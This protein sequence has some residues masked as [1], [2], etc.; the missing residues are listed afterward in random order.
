MEACNML[1]ISAA[2][3]QTCANMSGDNFYEFKLQNDKD[4]VCM[5][6]LPEAA[7]TG[8]VLPPPACLAEPKALFVLLRLLEGAGIVRLRMVGH[9]IKPQKEA[10]AAYD[11]ESTAPVIYVPRQR[12]A[13]GPQ[14][15]AASLPASTLKSS[16]FLKVV[17]KLKPHPW[18]Q[19]FAGKQSDLAC[20]IAHS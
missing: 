5:A 16:D 7:C 8:K 15:W 19:C 6:P 11:V 1:A 12:G 9:A 20:P 4:I 17:V 13:A 2:S 10:E 14:T 18:V 3:L